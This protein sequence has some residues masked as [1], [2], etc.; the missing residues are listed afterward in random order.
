MRCAFGREKVRLNGSG[1]W[2]GWLVGCLGE[3]DG[4]EV[5]YQRYPLY[6]SFHVYDKE[7]GERMVGTWDIPV[8]M[9]CKVL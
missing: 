2:D 1:R 6:V 4:T 9:Y 5:S 3:E 8:M 7:K